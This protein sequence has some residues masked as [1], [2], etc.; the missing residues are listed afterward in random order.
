MLKIFSIYDNKAKS[1]HQPLFQ[2][3]AVQAQRIF[4][5]EINRAAAD[6][7]LYHHPQDFDLYEL[8]EFDDQSGSLTHGQPVLISLG[9]ATKKE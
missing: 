9:A 2:Q 8:G 5:T 4:S 6:N 1:Y 7:L 3:S